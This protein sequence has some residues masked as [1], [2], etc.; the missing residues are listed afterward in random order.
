MSTPLKSGQ[1]LLFI[2]DSITECGRRDRTDPLGLGYVRI[3]A[4]ILSLREPTKRIQIVNRGIGG[5]KIEDLRSR[6]ADHVLA[7]R[8]SPG[9]GGRHDRHE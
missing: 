3:F 2:G 1:V 9:L 8:P 7:H 5:N 4:D 6:W